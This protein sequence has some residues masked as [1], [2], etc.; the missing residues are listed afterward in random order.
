[1]TKLMYAIPQLHRHEGSWVVT[2]PAGE[3][4]EL[5]E[6]ANVE[7]AVGAGWT[8]ETIGTYLG[9]INAAIL[10]LGPG[11]SQLVR[12]VADKT[13]ARPVDSTAHIAGETA[14][15]TVTDTAPG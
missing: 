2:S 12:T 15:F 10:N 11:E 9:R 5:F 3:V 4:V 7:K 8:V 1:M 13:E 6:R 14:Q